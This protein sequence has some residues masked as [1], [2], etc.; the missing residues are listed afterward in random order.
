MTARRGHIG[1]ERIEA[2]ETNK[3][4]EKLATDPY[5]YTWRG[6]PSGTKKLAAS[7]MDAVIEVI[8]LHFGFKVH[9]KLILDAAGTTAASLSHHRYDGQPISHR[10][11]FRLAVFSGIQYADLCEIAGIE[12]IVTPFIRVLKGNQ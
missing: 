4:L 11:L 2:M 5:A 8:Q 10:W 1:P 12:P 6:F 9:R 3:M 7:P